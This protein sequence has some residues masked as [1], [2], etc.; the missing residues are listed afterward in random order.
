MEKEKQRPMYNMDGEYLVLLQTSNHSIKHHLKV[1]FSLPLP[2]VTRRVI[3]IAHLK[4]ETVISKRKQTGCISGTLNEQLLRSN[5][6]SGH[7]EMTKARSG[8][9]R[10]S[11]R[12]HDK[13]QHS[14]W[15][16]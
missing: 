10:R 11:A 9:A 1:A 4:L 16:E 3:V 5:L 14:P 13:S 8:Q 2:L 12:L 7:E 15:E 6:Q